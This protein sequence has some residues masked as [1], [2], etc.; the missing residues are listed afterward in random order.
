MIMAAERR[1]ESVQ[2]PELI[3]DLAGA[4][5]VPDLAITGIA[6]HSGEVRPGYLFLACAGTRTS[7][8]RYIGEAAKAGAVAALA[9]AAGFDVTVHW[10][11]PV[12]P[13]P[14][15]AARAGHIAARFFGHPSRSVT[16]FGVTG[17]NGKTSVSHF[18]A[19]ALDRIAEGGAGLIG[20]IGW[21]RAGALAPSGLTT[22][23]AVT[24][25]SL[26][27]GM[28]A[29]GMRSV[30]MEV[31][32]HALEQG[33]VAGVEFSVAVFTN[34]TRD[35]LDYHGDMDAYGAAKARLFDQPGLRAAIVNLDDP[36]GRELHRRLA[37]RVP[38]T[39]YRI[40]A[41]GR[42]G[43][44][45][46]AAHIEEEGIGRLRLRISGPWGEWRLAAPLTGRF[47]AANLLAAFGAMCAAGHA[48]DAVAAALAQTRGVPGRMETFGRR[49]APAVIVD[50]AHTPDALDHALAALRPHCDGHLVCVFGCGGDRDRGKR[51]QMGAVAERHA[52]QIYVTSDNPRGEDPER[53][54]EEILAGMGRSVPVS[55]E[56][57]RGAAIVRAIREAGPRDVVL[58]AGKGHEEY[59]EIAGVRHDF[60]DRRLVASLVGERE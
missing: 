5:E 24:L 12:F 29:L 21:G 9:D 57:D 44:E 17:T 42:A 54:I 35:H 48:P 45:E 13:V 46:L 1:G 32:S 7:G 34:L 10:P 15:L 30:A 3:A 59:Q 23:D 47:N 22:P 53:I 33:R 60:S 27:A 14:D 25:Q 49:G 31:S 6:M 40:A 11:I 43:A 19:A 2:L 16:V 4:A 20:T 58:V 26:L 8:A 51:P 28:R 18:I 55:V 37:G 39:G 52:D 38:V 50:Y 56:P 41:P 36:F